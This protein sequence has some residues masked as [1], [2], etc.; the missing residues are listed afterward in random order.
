MQDKVAEWLRAGALLVWALYPSTRSAMAC[1]SDGEARLLNA[2]D[3]LR[4][5]PVLPGFACR[6]GDLFA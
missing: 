1:G 4:G 5:E 3:A 2:E 6:V